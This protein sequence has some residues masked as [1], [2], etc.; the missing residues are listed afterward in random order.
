[1]I[2]GFVIGI[3]GMIYLS[4]LGA[5]PALPYKI[6][7]S[8]M[9]SFGLLSIVYNQWPLFTGKAGFAETKEDHKKLLLTLLAN[10]CGVLIAFILAMPILN[11]AAI[12]YCKTI[13]ADKMSISLPVMFC[14]AFGCGIMMYLAVY[15]WKKT[16]NP[17]MV[18]MPVMIFI[19]CGFEH[20]IA[21]WFYFLV[22]SASWRMFIVMP[23]LLVGN[24]AGS[25]FV[26]NYLIEGLD[27]NLLK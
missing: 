13:C 11:P 3:G 10:I 9:F 12:E 27:K 26:K 7:A 1:M 19:L 24:Y 18:I 15:G 22:G 16:Q 21:D 23:I 20:S 14:K 25:Q 5:N 6:I 4:I 17:L 8:F 2:A